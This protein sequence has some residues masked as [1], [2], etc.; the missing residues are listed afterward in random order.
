MK[1]NPFSGV[2]LIFFIFRITINVLTKK[3]IKLEN[4]LIKATT[5]ISIVLKTK[6]YNNKGLILTIYCIKKR[7]KT[8]LNKLKPINTA[9]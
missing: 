9:F 6:K 3:G 8:V 2:T 1:F 7:I 4:R 5:V